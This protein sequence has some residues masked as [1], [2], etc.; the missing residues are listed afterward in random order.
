MIASLSALVADTSGTAWHHDREVGLVVVSLVGRHDRRVGEVEPC[1]SGG[2][3]CD[4]KVSP[5]S[6]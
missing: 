5:T 6:S 1:G 4:N 2:L 3:A